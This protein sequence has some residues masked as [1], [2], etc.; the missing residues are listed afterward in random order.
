MRGTSAS[1]ICEAL[2]LADVDVEILEKGLVQGT[3]TSTSPSTSHPVI[4][5]ARLTR[6]SHTHWD[7]LIIAQTYF[8][9]SSRLMWYLLLLPAFA[10]PFSAFSFCIFEFLLEEDTDAA[11]ETAA[12]GEFFVETW[13]VVPGV[14]PTAALRLPAETLSPKMDGGETFE[15]YVDVHV[16]RSAK[17]RLARGV[18][19]RREIS[20]Q[21]E[22][23]QEFL[24]CSVKFPFSRRRL[25]KLCH[26]SLNINICLAFHFLAFPQSKHINFH[27]HEHAEL[28]HLCSNFLSVVLRQDPCRVST[29][30][31]SSQNSRIFRIPRASFISRMMFLRPRRCLR[32]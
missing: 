27:E 19:N 4:R 21:V 16:A 9:R 5:T 23:F 29:S 15:P 12:L 18:G 22:G 10:F 2:D 25:P 7:C 28:R 14:G 20:F 13:A 11:T 30:A 1:W 8:F 6:Y 26:L 32:S 24:H 17:G 31:A 3:Q